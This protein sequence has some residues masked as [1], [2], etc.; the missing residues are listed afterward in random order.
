MLEISNHA[1]S[2]GEDPHSNQDLL[3]P[4]PRIADRDAPPDI[5]LILTH[6][7]GDNDQCLA[8]AEALGRPFRSIA[9][10]WPKSSRT[11]DRMNLAKLLRDDQSGLALRAAA[12]LQAPWPR[13]VIC[14]GRRADDLAFWIRRQSNENTRV[15]TIGRAHAALA[16]YDL[17]IGSPQYL[18]PERANVVQLPMPMARPW[19]D[20]P[21]LQSVARMRAP[22]PWFT[23][24]LGGH[25]KQFAIDAVS[26]KQAALL[27]QLAADRT[28]GTVIISTSR[29]TPPWLLEVVED[30]L[31]SPVVYRWSAQCIDNPYATLLDSSAA[32]FVT[33]DSSSMILDAC[34]SG[35]PTYLIELPGRI[36]GRHFW[37]RHLY[38]I[39]RGTANAFREVGFAFA[40]AWVDRMQEWL[41]AARL[42]KFPRDLRRLHA[43]VFA[44]DLAQPA[45]EFQPEVLPARRFVELSVDATELERAIAQCL[46]WVNQD[47]VQEM[48]DQFGQRNVG[49][50]QCCD[51]G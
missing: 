47:G 15:V 34:R 44:M 31:T 22:K 30:E 3:N 10:D 16:D 7:I 1:L 45:A 43:Q 42:L 51:H 4:Q 40:A 36:D 39:I 14:S 17:V 25:V 13:L 19:I 21:S 5:W 6:A 50:T 12:G 35:T 8:F 27:A 33:A 32:I 9:L 46:A 23:L 26:L 11:I 29:R 41:H 20:I 38:G 49:A 48:A 18:L 28:G 37:R 24:L 2:M